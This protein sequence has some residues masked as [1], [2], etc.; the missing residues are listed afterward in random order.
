MSM[1]IAVFVY[2][3]V[4]VSKKKLESGE[5]IRVVSGRCSKQFYR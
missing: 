5:R 1:N 2:L 4:V 3:E